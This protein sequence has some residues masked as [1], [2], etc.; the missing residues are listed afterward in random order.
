MF[1]R[2]IDSLHCYRVGTVTVRLRYVAEIE[3][4]TVL[5]PGTGCR[6]YAH[7]CADTQRV[8]RVQGLGKDSHVT[9]GRWLK[10]NSVVAVDARYCHAEECDMQ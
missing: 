9:A 6:E 4:V 5:P 7:S 1:V 2:S 3:V 8:A 10:K